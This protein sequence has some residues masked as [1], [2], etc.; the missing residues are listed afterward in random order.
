MK[1]DFLTIL[2]CSVV[3]T[4]VSLLFLG[5]RQL[6]GPAYSARWR[7]ISWLFL[8]LGFLIPYRP[9]P[10]SPLFTAT[11]PALASHSPVRPERWI[12][13]FWLFGVMVAL[14]LRLIQHIQFTQ[15]VRRLSHPISD[16][17][18][19]RWFQQV[20]LEMGMDRRI[21][22]FQVSGISSPML[23]GLRHP[24]VLLPDQAFSE[25]ELTLIFRH[26]LIHFQRKDL[27][28]QCLLE[29]VHC[30]HWFNPL[31]PLLKKIIRADLE[32]ACDERIT[33]YASKEERALYCKT[34]LHVIR[35]KS[36][37]Q[38]ALSTSFGNGPGELKQRFEEIF[39]RKKKR[40][41][42]GIALLIL[43]LTAGS[44]QLFAV[45]QSGNSQNFGGPGET[46]TTF[47]ADDEAAAGEVSGAVGTTFSLEDEVPAGAASSDSFPAGLNT[48]EVS[49]DE[50]EGEEA[51]TT[52]YG[53]S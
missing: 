7:R 35:Q 47:I 12:F 30:I 8:L 33:F 13:L 14:A 48:G 27:W 44:S 37:L 34:I 26:E 16:E 20:C 49:W 23:T 45:T 29:L 41:F 50:K 9:Q 46:A 42:L 6:T 18:I 22:L 21:G 11:I 10:A 25:E 1:N 40:A 53:T 51:Y 32:C 19:S 17:N 31:F 43:L 36:T 38:S 2:T 3:M 15:S 5:L 28:Y 24:C 4:G 39:S 52:V